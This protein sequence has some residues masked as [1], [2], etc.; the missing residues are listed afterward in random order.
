MR[1]LRTRG[2]LVVACLLAI[3]AVACGNESSG[4]KGGG[5]DGGGG[6]QATVDQPGVSADTI[7]VGGVASIT[8]PLNAPYGDIFKGV[9]AYF[10]MVNKEGGIYGRKLE[11]TSQRDD[12]VTNNLREV[13]GLI[14]EDDV[15][16][17]VGMA[18]I[19]DFSGGSQALEANGMPTFGWNINADWNK[20]NLFGNSGALCIGCEG[21]ELP[22]MAKQ[23]DKH[24]IGVLAYSVDNSKK[25]AEGVRKSFEKF[26]S[27]KIGFY[28][29]SLSFGD[30]DFSVEV[31]QMKD[32][33]VDFITTCMDTNG[34]LAIAKEARK[35]EL[36]AIQYLPNGYDQEFMKANGQFFEGSYVRV[37]FVPFETKPRPKGL[38]EYLTWMERQGDTP[39]EL[40]TYGWIGA[41]QLVEGLRAAGPNFTQKKVVDALNRM[42][43]DTAGGLI[44]PID[45]TT[46]H[47]ETRPP[48]SCAALVKV[49]DKKFVPAFV[50]KGKVYICFPRD[51]TL[52]TKPTYR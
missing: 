40:T 45:W 32:A 3:V 30:V 48:V 11:V 19:F 39:N 50:P 44:P 10:A 31:S 25:C 47:T 2:L 5:G 38:D 34:V 49:H 33:G 17:A 1:V 29:D 4:S 42:K 13:Q 36:D 20:P 27:A 8:N 6:K 9:K 12:Q 15:F 35:Q 23:L 51:A 24:V 41:A 21:V 26:P 28:S 14:S 46:Q 22:Y 43:D 37:P 18:T 16:A 7:K 52:T